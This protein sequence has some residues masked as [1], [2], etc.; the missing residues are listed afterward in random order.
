MGYMMTTLKC[1]HDLDIGCGC[2]DALS[3]YDEQ[4]TR[5]LQPLADALTLHVR[6]TTD[7][8]VEQT[9][10]GV[11]CAV[12]TLGAW[13]VYANEEGWSIEDADGSIAIG[14]WGVIGTDDE[15]RVLEDDEDTGTLNADECDAAV[16]MLAAVVPSLTRS[17]VR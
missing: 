7:A 12:A 2:M 16:M 5:A 6:G 8:R 10:G 3:D 9:G 14:G 1:G 15:Y 17:T 11:F 13:T 4:R